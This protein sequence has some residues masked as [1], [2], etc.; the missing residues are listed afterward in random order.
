[1]TEMKIPKPHM[2]E[3]SRESLQVIQIA[4]SNSFLGAGI[5]TLWSRLYGGQTLAQ[6]CFSASLTVEDEFPIHSV[7]SYFILSG[8]SKQ[9]ILF[10]VDRTRDGKSFK[11]RACRAIQSN[12]TVCLSQMSFHRLESGLRFDLDIKSLV[13]KEHWG[14]LS[15][16][17]IENA[18]NDTL[19]ENI[20]RKILLPGPG[21]F[22]LAMRSRCNIEKDS[23]RKNCGMLAFLS[24]LCQIDTIR[25]QFPDDTEW[26]IPTSSLDH[27][28]HFHQPEKI[29]TEEWLLFCCLPQTLQANRGLSQCYVFNLQ[30]E[31]LATVAQEALIRVVDRDLVQK[32]KMNKKQAKL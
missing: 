6:S 23:W 32:K 14:K 7:H 10:E 1:M 28:I 12:R 3:A 30:N 21:V 31:H 4:G 20:E 2:M 5:P 16:K 26:Y 11:T 15:Q 22:L 18:P 13:P 9:E 17:Y 24:D 29:W 19:W 27:S 8:D 25:K